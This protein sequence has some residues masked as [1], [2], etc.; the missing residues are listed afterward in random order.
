MY[1]IMYSHFINTCIL[2]CIHTHTQLF[3]ECDHQGQRNTR[4]APVVKRYAPV[5]HEEQQSISEHVRERRVISPRAAPPAPMAE[6]NSS[7]YCLSGSLQVFT[8]LAEKICDGGS[9]GGSN[10]N[11]WTG[12]TFG[13]YVVII[14]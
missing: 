6:M 10:S 7:S 8:S 1:N 14:P 9:I 5:L 2:T 12:V 13:G 3:L 11:C 4:S